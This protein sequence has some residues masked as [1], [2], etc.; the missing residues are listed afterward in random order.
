MRLY[1]RK[2]YLKEKRRDKVDTTTIADCFS[3][4]RIYSTNQDVELK[5]TFEFEALSKPLSF[6]TTLPKFI[7]SKKKSI[8]LVFTQDPEQA[9]KLGATIAGGE[10]LFEGI[11]DG[12]IVFD[13]CVS[14]KAMFPK[15]IK[16]ARILGP[17]GLMPS[18]SRGRYLFD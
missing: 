2:K 5:G 11:E 12:T 4:S 17:K 7:E 16:L 13:T 18:P 14:T 9:I 6:S 1:D 8:I 15:V 3:I 10:E